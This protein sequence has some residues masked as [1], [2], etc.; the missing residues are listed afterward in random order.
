MVYLS[1]DKG[2][3]LIKGNVKTPYGKWDPR[4][5]AYRAKSMYYPDIL[6]YFKQSKIPIQ[7]NVMNVPPSENLLNRVN[8]RSYQKQALVN[9]KRNK[10]RG[11]IVLP[12]AAGKTYLALKAIS[13]LKTQT[14]IVVP[15]LDLIDQWRNKIKDFLDIDSGAI[16]GGEN[17]VRMITVSTYDSAYLKAAV[18]G[19][20][21][22]FLIFDEVH[23]LAS[24][25]YMQI[26]EMY[27]APYRMGLT[28]TYERIDERHKILPNLIGNIVFSLDVE[29]LA[30]SHLSPYIYE[31]IYVKLNPNDQKKYYNE[32]KVFRNY[33]RDKRII[34]RSARDFQK[35]I[36][37]TGRDPRARKAL[38][39]RNNALKIALNSEEKI[40]L[41]ASQLDSHPGAKILIFTLHNNLVYQ[42]STRF[43][44][45][46][47]T[48]QTPKNERREIL[49]RFRNGTYNILVT[50][51]VLDEGIDVPEASIGYILSGTGSSREYIQRLGR[52][53]RKVEGKKA[54]LYEIVSKETV[55]V[56]ISHR[57]SKKPKKVA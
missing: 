1:F 20:K 14:L 48:Y 42:I 10:K 8:L 4:V 27:A 21:F 32:M 46:S 6:D 28:A 22:N 18:L 38:L 2:T 53:L 43:L 50:S 35:F 23:H 33:I 40:N 12:T 16:G 57:R 45:P 54:R 30:G 37:L 44:I 47:I 11:I 5:G 13:D 49:E 15:T 36:M 56:K 41:L 31:K 51:Q 26:A 52:L 24:Q 17:V 7:D 19:N 25:S 34:M 55:E 39:A 29:D 9:W 3:L